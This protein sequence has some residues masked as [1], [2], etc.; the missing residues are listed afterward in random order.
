MKQALCLCLSIANEAAIAGGGSGLSN[1]TSLSLWA[2]NGIPTT[3][4]GTT[5]TPNDSSSAF[6]TITATNVDARI[7]PTDT[8]VED[9][10]AETHEATWIRFDL[11][12][13]DNPLNFR[14]TAADGVTTQDYSATIH[15]LTAG[16]AE[17]TRL[18]CGSDT[19]SNTNGS[20]LLIYTAGGVSVGVHLGG[21]TPPTDLAVNAGLHENATGA[22]IAYE[23]HAALLMA[24][25]FTV[26]RDG[27]NITLTNTQAGPCTDATWQGAGEFYVSVLTQGE[28]PS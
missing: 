8:N 10:V 18:E 21:S 26:S 1:D 15:M 11:E 24:G 4:G 14:V 27:P 7:A 16:V 3:E 13:G 5:N 22:D 23:I 19:D 6:I 2:V 9:V 20:Y 25:I 17:V 12:V 28:N